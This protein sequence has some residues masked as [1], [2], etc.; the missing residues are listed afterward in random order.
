[1]RYVR[2]VNRVR[3]REL[4]ARIGVADRWWLRLRGLGGRAGLEPGEGLLLRPCRAV[5]MMGMK[6]PLDV[7]FLDAGNRVVA[8]YPRL[9]PGARTRWHRGALAVLELPAGTLDETGTLEGDLVEYQEEAA[10]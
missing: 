7:A 8:R 10:R 3:D 1:L 4:G 9:S 6:F 5:H 2:A